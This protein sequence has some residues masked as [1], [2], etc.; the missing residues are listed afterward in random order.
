MPDRLH[1][2]HAGAFKESGGI[3]HRH[4]RKRQYRRTFLMKEY[5]TNSYEETVALGESV[6]KKLKK[7]SVVAFIGGLGM[8]KTAFTTGLAKGLGIDADV[9][10]PTFAIC[11]TLICTVLTDGTTFTQRDFLIFSTP[12]RI[13]LWSGA[14]M[15][16]VLSRRIH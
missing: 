5:V 16:T 6:A 4:R 11:T 9:S 13:W 3:Q 10:S 1:N 12:E 8:G 15:F 2:D 14:R 7:G